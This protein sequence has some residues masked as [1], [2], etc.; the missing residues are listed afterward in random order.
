MCISL[1]L[2]ID[3]SLSL[4][5][6]IYTPMCTY[7]IIYNN[8]YIY[9]CVC[10]YIYIYIYIYISEGGLQKPRVDF[11]VWKSRSCRNK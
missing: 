7:D 8:V 2:Y 5:I 10:I 1:S 4:Y 11:L 6:Y 9:V 3:L